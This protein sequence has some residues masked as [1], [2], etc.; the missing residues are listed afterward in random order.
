MSVFRS[1]K[2]EAC[3]GVIFNHLLNSPAIYTKVCDTVCHSIFMM[4]SKSQAHFILSVLF[5]P[6]KHL[7][8]ITLNNCLFMLPD[9]LKDVPTHQRLCAR[10]PRTRRCEAEPGVGWLV[11]T[12]LC[13]SSWVVWRSRHGGRANCQA[14]SDC[15]V[16]VTPTV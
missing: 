11:H 6:H 14:R 4:L 13:M 8:G 1:I 7:G 5:L 16:S 15:T 3:N 10:P 12:H 9:F 2:I